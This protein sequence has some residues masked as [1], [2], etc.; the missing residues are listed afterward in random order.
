M[1]LIN[2]SSL[3]DIICRYKFVLPFLKNKK[4][5]EVGCGFGIGAR[6]INEQS[7]LY[8]GIDIS[9]SNIYKA[10]KNNGKIRNCFKELSAYQINQAL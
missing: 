5:L 1:N 8:R 6:L 3:E 2:K 7:S 4:V 9:K 10:K